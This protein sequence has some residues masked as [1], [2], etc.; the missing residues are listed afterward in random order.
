MVSPGPACPRLS[1]VLCAV[2]LGGVAACSPKTI[3]AVDPF[4]C[5]DGGNIA[6]CPNLTDGLVGFW[7]LNETSGTS[8]RDSSAWGNDGTLEGLDPMM[9]WVADGPEGEALSVEA[10]GH[11]SVPDS[12]S[13]DTVTSH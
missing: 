8:A 5:S 10:K 12:P 3:V 2:L 11:V 1:A 13:I 7:R 9:S 4:P 6:G